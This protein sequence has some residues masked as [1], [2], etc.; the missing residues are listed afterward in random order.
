MEQGGGHPPQ[1][2]RRSFTSPPI[3]RRV[4]PAYAERQRALPR[5]GDIWV[6]KSAVSPNHF[7]RLYILGVED[8]FQ[9]E[10]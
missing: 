10:D 4:A 9:E 2:Y 7:V 3:L 6:P 5:L 1:N 8:L